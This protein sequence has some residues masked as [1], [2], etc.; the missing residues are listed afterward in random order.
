MSFLSSSNVNVTQ[1]T[2]Q[3]LQ[4]DVVVGNG[5]EDSISDLAFSPQAE[6][7][8]V[9]SWDKKVRV[10]EVLPTGTTEG[11]ALYDHESPV[12]A[13]HWSPDGTKVATGA[14]DRQVRLYDVQTGQVQNLGTHEAPV[15]ALRFVEVGPTSTPVVVSG[16]WDKTLRYWDPRSAQPMATVA[17]PER[18]YAMDTSQKLLVVAT[19]ERHIGV[20]D[21]NQPQQLFKQTMSPLKWQT[22]TVACYPQGNGY[23]IGS[24]EGRC[25]L[26]YID[27]TEQA[28]SGFSF[29]CHRVPRPAPAKESDV[30]SINS[31]RFHPVYGTFSTAG[32]D[33]AF[34]FWDKDQKHRLK[35]FPAGPT[36]IS[37]TAFNRNGGIF[38]YAYSYDWSKG[39]EGNSAN[40]PIQLRLHATKDEEVKQRNKK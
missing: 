3:D 23:A 35:G 32:S 20:I 7:L 12:L 11:R 27:A 8:A 31:I 29:K 16:G 2:V 9:A 39:P 38:A 18:V 34:H 25:C 36:S 40:T 17:L 28:K 33:G 22:R 6:L 13:V 5:P 19:A 15:K 26:Q 14:A 37:S 10:Y 24:I 30:Y 1:G 4:N 21:L